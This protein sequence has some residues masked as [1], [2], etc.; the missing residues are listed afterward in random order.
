[1]YL[2]PLMKSSKSI[3]KL[4]VA[5]AREV[6]QF[7][8]SLFSRVKIPVVPIKVLT[9]DWKLRKKF[10]IWQFLF[11]H[12]TCKAFQLTVWHIMGIGNLKM[13]IWPLTFHFYVENKTREVCTLSCFRWR[14]GTP[15]M[16]NPKIGLTICSVPWWRGRFPLIEHIQ[17][18][19]SF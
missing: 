19:A 3:K 5:V 2:F 13:K 14:K 11:I 9:L 6:W 7:K 8:C 1:M 10:W 16:T 15:W 18:K 4:T 17:S 12:V